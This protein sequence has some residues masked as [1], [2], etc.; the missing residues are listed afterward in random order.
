MFYPIMILQSDRRTKDLPHARI[1]SWLLVQ[2]RV[3]ILK[4][5]QNDRLVVHRRDPSVESWRF[6]VL[7]PR[8]GC[9]E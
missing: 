6:L 4:Q 5:F 1:L 8:A 7:R 3:Q 9:D 2:R